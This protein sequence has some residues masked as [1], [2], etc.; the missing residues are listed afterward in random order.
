VT[1]APTLI[2]SF[3][4]PTVKRFRALAARKHRKREGAFTVEGLQPVWFAVR[5]AWP[6]DTLIVAPDLL[7]NEPAWQ[8]VDEAGRGGTAVTWVSRDVFAHLSDRDG[9]AGLAA[10]VRGSV[11]DVAQF[12]PAATGPVVALHR[13]GN[14]GNIGTILRS[15]DAAGA[16]GLLLVGDCADPLSPGAVKASMGSLFAVPLAAAE[17]ED[18]LFDWAAA[19]GRPVVAITGNTTDTLWGAT[20]PAHAVLL[21]GSEGDGLPDDLVRR[22]Q[23]ALSIPMQG[24]AESLNLATATS[25]A[26]FEL[27]RRRIVGE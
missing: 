22:C 19:A 26:L 6:V 25:I 17:S 10:I 14:P 3:A 7:T 9:P 8:M 21:M 23:A 24:S 2:T 18:A 12:R 27:S 13:V 11:G 16:A 20:V 4:N 1:D 15:A 5:S